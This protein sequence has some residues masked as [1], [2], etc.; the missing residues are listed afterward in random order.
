MDEKN[1]R[2]QTYEQAAGC[3]APRLMTL[4][5]ALPDEIRASVEE[6]RLRAGQPISWAANGQEHSLSA[7]CVRAEELRDTLAR[8][9]RWSVHTF[10]EPLSQGYLPLMGGHR[11]G[12][13][14]TVA[15]SDGKIQGIR[16][17]SSLSLRIAREW[18][19]VAAPALPEIWD[20]I[21]CVQGT[22]ILSAPGGGKTTFL[23]DLIRLLSQNGVRVGV[24]DTR[25][26]LAAMRGG[27]PQFEL[28]GQCDVL[29]GCPKALAALQLV[30][31][32]TPQVLALDE[33]TDPADLDAIQYAANC[34]VAVLA[35]IHAAGIEELR[36]KPFFRALCDSGA[37]TKLVVL[38]AGREGRSCQVM[39][40]E[41]GKNRC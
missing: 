7:E 5:M 31:T 32:M 27:L 18:Q 39:A 15:F 3:L 22:L 2:L 11:L 8:A 40:L 28:G 35:T 25:G 41:G 4:A 20:G 9:S 6:L 29:D 12:V 24:A 10:H 30:R 34:G 16:T 14:G 26:E 37:F 17:V 21:H 1:T 23:R 13:C 36:R 33:V 19:G 38:T